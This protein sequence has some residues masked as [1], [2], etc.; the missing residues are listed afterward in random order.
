MRQDSLASGGASPEDARRGREA[1]KAAASHLRLTGRTRYRTAAV[2]QERARV[3]V[4]PKLGPM[5]SSPGTPLSSTVL[6]ET[7]RAANLVRSSCSGAGPC[8]LP[9]AAAARQR[10]TFPVAREAPH[11]AVAY[12]NFLETSNRAVGSDSRTERAIPYRS[13]CGDD[14]RP[15]G[16]TGRDT[17]RSLRDSAER[18]TLTARPSPCPPT[19]GRRRGHLR[20]RGHPVEDRSE[21]PDVGPVGGPVAG[22]LRGERL[23][24]DIPSRRHVRCRTG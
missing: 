9:E 1:G 3:C 2:C 24:V 21:F 10:S 5:L 22:L 6:G 15:P 14:R 19:S 12:H 13:L 16:P 4:F 17:A 20:R 23:G 18:P 8:C 7:H 11:E